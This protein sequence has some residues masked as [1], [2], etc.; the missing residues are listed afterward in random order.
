MLRFV[1]K[2]MVVLDS[3]ASAVSAGSCGRRWNLTSCHRIA[4]RHPG[5]D[6]CQ[7]LDSVI[8]V[9]LATL[10]GSSPLTNT[11]HSLEPGCFAYSFR[12]RSALGG[13]V[14]MGA[15]LVVAVFALGVQA[16]R[17]AFV[18]VE[19][20][21][22]FFLLALRAAFGRMQLRH[23][24]FLVNRLCSGSGAGHEPASGPHYILPV[25]LIKS[26]LRRTEIFCPQ[27]Q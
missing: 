9:P 15:D 7:R 14:V 27:F 6:L 2:M 5:A 8:P 11:L 21:C 19:L 12:N 20:R 24:R 10:L 4:D 25:S 13:L 26:F 3:G 17:R 1:T 23:G 18:S 22:R 16:V